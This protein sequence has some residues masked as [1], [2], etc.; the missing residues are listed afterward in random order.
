MIAYYAYFGRDPRGKSVL[1]VPDNLIGISD[2]NDYNFDYD[3]A[4]LKG[5]SLLFEKKLMT[6]EDLLK[7]GW[8]IRRLEIPKRFF[9]ELQDLCSRQNDDDIILNNDIK[10]KAMEIADY[11]NDLF[12][13]SSS[14][15]CHCTTCGNNLSV[16]ENLDNESRNNGQREVIHEGG[17]RE[18]LPAEEFDDYHRDWWKKGNTDHWDEMWDL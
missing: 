3:P 5:V 1:Y 9:S 11:F 12:D 8:D 7:K 2:G 10:K 13:S 18:I 16:D 15:N 6:L 17:Y 4:T 14:A